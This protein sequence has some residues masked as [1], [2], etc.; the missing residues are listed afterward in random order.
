MYRDKLEKLRDVYIY[1]P[2]R[3]FTYD[4]NKYN[5]EHRPQFQY[6]EY[7][8]TRFKFEDRT[9]SSQSDVNRTLNAY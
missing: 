6:C 1:I 4:Y 3:Y 7:V 9:Y 2:N 8:P 5:N